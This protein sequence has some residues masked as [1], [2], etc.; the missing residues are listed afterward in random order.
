MGVRVSSLYMHFQ[1]LIV[2]VEDCE[3]CYSVTGVISAH[4][5]VV[6]GLKTIAFTLVCSVVAVRP[7]PPP[8][9]VW[10]VRSQSVLNA[11]WVHLRLYF[12]VVKYYPVAVQ[13]PKMH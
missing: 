6:C 4:A 3:Q 5:V 9:V 12:H 13:S 1:T 8:E 2:F 7:E 10:L 11:S